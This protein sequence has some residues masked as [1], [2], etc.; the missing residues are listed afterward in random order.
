MGLRAEPTRN[1]RAAS[2]FFPAEGALSVVKLACER[3]DV[4]GRSLSPW[5]SAELARPL[6]HDR[7]VEAVSPQTSQRMLASHQLKPWWHHL[8][9]SPTGPREATLAGQVT[10]MVTF[11][12]AP[13]AP[14]KW[15]CGWTRKPISSHGPARHPRGPR[16]RASRYG[17]NMHRRGRER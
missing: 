10:D 15:G 13:W 17:S 9:L 8:W 4:M 14:E 1:V 2:P 6:V 12:H 3:P 16:H 7:V 11:Y 5:D